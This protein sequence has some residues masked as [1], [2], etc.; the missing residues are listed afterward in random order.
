MTIWHTLM[1][2]W[3]RS[4]LSSFDLGAKFSLVWCSLFQLLFFFSLVSSV[5]VWMDTDLFLME[6]KK[7]VVCDSWSSVCH[8]R[9][10]HLFFAF[11]LFQ[12]G[13]SCQNWKRHLFSSKSEC[14]NP[15]FYFFGGV[16]FMRTFSRT[17]N[18][19]TEILPSFS[20]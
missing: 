6:G 18:V 5:Q 3:S 1:S 7:N 19:L 15:S 14:K 13:S 17:V 4:V 9:S 8:P 10:C 2:P 12:V 11:V 20:L 16:I